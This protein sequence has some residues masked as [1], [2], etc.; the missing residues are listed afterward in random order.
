MRVYVRREK[1]TEIRVYNDMYIRK[2]LTV[3]LQKFVSNSFF[4]FLIPKRNFVAKTLIN[5]PYLICEFD[6]V[7][8]WQRFVPHYFCIDVLSNKAYHADYWSLSE[9]NPWQTPLL[10]W[11][12]KA[13]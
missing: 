1:D 8:F 10:D 7:L 13:E 9:S 11:E 2:Y 4:E 12:G 6:T 3:I 5:S